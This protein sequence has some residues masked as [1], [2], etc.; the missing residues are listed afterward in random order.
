MGRE[1]AKI[2]SW[3]KLEKRLQNA[4]KWPKMG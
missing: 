2:K 4:K 1:F 3:S